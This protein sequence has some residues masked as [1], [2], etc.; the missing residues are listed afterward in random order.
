MG[1]Y[2]RDLPAQTVVQISCMNDV[3]A[4]SDRRVPERLLLQP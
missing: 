3:P 2:G 1:G 4:I